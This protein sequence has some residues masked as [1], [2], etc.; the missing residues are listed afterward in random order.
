MAAFTGSPASTKQRV[1]QVNG[2]PESF[3]L[4]NLRGKTVT[5]V[6]SL[7]AGTG[8]VNLYKLP[9]GPIRLLTNLCSFTAS[10]FGALATLDLG[11]REYV[12]N[13][14]DT[15]A[16]DGNA[17]LSAADVAAGAT[18]KTF[19]ALPA[20]GFIDFNS[21][22]GVVIFATIGTG[23]IENDDTIRMNLYWT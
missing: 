9:A 1:D 15:Q 3:S 6:H 19:L 23:N 20:A 10:Q 16:E 12:D 7:G 4:A 21:A 14:G 13:V 8:E 22:A 11:Y 18:T 2:I 5:Y 17:F